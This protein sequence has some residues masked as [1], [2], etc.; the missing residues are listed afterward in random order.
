MPRKKARPAAR[1]SQA[2]LELRLKDGK[3]R[4]RIY[5]TPYFPPAHP[6]ALFGLAM[7]ASAGSAL[8]NIL[9]DDQDI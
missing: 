4:R 2:K 7:A 6:T 5:A 9:D 1:K 3:P 8:R